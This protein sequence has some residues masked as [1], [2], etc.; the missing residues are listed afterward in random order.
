MI[1]PER[2]ITSELVRDYDIVFGL[3]EIYSDLYC[4][5]IIV[6]GVVRGIL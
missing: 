5:P 4:A 1:V 6:F 2:R 3:V